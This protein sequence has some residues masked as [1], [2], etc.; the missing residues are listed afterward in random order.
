[1]KHF[2]RIIYGL[3]K[4]KIGIVEDKQARYRYGR[5]RVVY[6]DEHATIYYPEWHLEYLD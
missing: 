6:R 5:V 4:G 2:V 3:D 1:M